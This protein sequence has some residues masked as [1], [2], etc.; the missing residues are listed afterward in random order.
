VGRRRRRVRED[1]RWLLAGL[2]VSLIIFL[3]A[4]SRHGK[5]PDSSEL[6]PLQTQVVAPGRPNPTTA[7]LHVGE[8]LRIAPTAGPAGERFATV[9]SERVPSDPVL[10]VDSA[11][12]ETPLVRGART[13][14]VVVTVLLEPMC[15][16][17]GVCRQYRQNLGA[18]RVTVVP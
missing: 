9:V 14:T 2:A 3:V 16:S 18:V 4:L 10:E 15:P 5:A 11:R 17:E 12:G 13:G 6:P 1:P 7:R 8:Y